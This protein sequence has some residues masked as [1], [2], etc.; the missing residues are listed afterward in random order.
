MLF[1]QEIALAILVGGRLYAEDLVGGTLNGGTLDLG[2]LLQ[3][4]VGVET[5]GH[6]PLDL[7]LRTENLVGV[8]VGALEGGGVERH[9]EVV[10]RNEFRDGPF[11]AGAVVELLE[12]A[13]K[14]GQVQEEAFLLVV[15]V[16]HDVRKL[17]VHELADAGSLLQL[18]LVR[19]T[20]D[21]SLNRAAARKKFRRG[22]GLELDAVLD[23]ERVRGRACALERLGDL[24]ELDAQKVETQLERLLPVGAGLAVGVPALPNLGADVHQLV[25]GQA[26]D[27]VGVVL[28][29]SEVGPGSRLGLTKFQ[30]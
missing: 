10:G 28:H 30:F 18:L 29:G 17:V 14:N 6:V 22:L 20:T 15:V 2:G 23:E 7:M 11:G 1:Q 27:G 24:F 3:F 12:C 25:F 19:H 21:L 4:D 13:A 5:V 16:L 26:L 9:D 8:A